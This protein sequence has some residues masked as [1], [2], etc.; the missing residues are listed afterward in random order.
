MINIMIADN[1]AVIREGLKNLVEFDENIQVVAEAGDGNECV[2]N[3]LMVNPDVLLFDINMLEINGVEFL[4]PI[5]KREKRPKILIL[6][7]YNELEHL[8]KSIDMG[9]DGYIFKNSNSKELIN[10]I[11]DV[12]NG[13]KFV[14]PSFF[15]FLNSKYIVSNIDDDKIRL[16]SEREIELLKLIVFGLTNKEIS[17]KLFISE[18]TVKNHLSNIFKKIDCADRTQAAVFCIRNR[19][20]DI[21]DI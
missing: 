9:V 20:V 19:L 11:K 6:T 13:S 21:N 14:Q 7:V 15:S 1:R 4:E 2:N 18:C 17:G 5:C 3:L 10:A 12:Y 8:I 16:L